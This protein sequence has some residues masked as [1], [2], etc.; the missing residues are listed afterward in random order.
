MKK[1]KITIQ[2]KTYI[3]EVAITQEEKQTGLQNRKSL[4]PDEGMLF[5]YDKQGTQQFW[6]K[7]TPIPLDQIAINSSEI[8]NKVYTALPNDE[9]LVSFPKCKYLLEVNANS[10]IQEGDEV[11]FDEEDLSD[12][13]MKV[14]GSD[15]GTQML[16]KG[17]ERIFSRKSTLK[18]I[19]LAKLAN[20]LNEDPEEYD[21][22]CIKLGKALFKELYAQDHREQQY[23]DLPK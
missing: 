1:I 3:C 15:G 4:A 20:E 7:D 19:R 22:I 23:V 17:G 11:E 2:D 21:K 14:L 12:Y 5:I 13:T 10:G 9:T 16:L 18:F 6:M 8:V